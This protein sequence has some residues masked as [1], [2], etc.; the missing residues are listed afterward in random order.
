MLRREPD[1]SRF[2]NS[3]NRVTASQ[4]Y[5]R[6]PPSK[7]VSRS[8]HGAGSRQ[9]TP[10][11]SFR[12]YNRRVSRR[13][14]RRKGVED[15]VAAERLCLVSTYPPQRCGI[16][17]YTASLARALAGTGVAP[18]VI[19]ELGAH[20]GEDGGVLSVPTF[21]RNADYVAAVEASIVETG[22]TVVHVQHA[23]DIFGTDGRMPRL[24]ARLRRRGIA[25]A[26][27][28]HTVHT[29]W[30]GLLERRFGVAQFHRRLAE[31]A[32]AIVV[33][34]ARQMADE[35]ARQG[36]DTSKLSV[37]PHG[38]P[39]TPVVDR[40]L[41]RERL[42]LP[43]E[44]PMVLCFGFIHPQKNLHTVLLAT[45]EFSRRIPNCRLYLAGSLQ[46]ASWP[47]RLY[48]RLLRAIVRW[49]GLSDRVVLREEFVAED[50]MALLYAAADLVLLPYAQ[51]YG[52][53]SGVAHGAVGAAR[54]PV[55]SASPKFAEVG[56]AI[57]HGLI[58][59]T[60]SPRAWANTIA[61]LLTDEARRAALV[62][63]V[64]TFAKD[65]SWAAVAA[66]HRALYRR[67]AEA[68]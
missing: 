48:L 30:S 68:R 36:V 2:D 65:T 46:N 61:T 67:L 33:H 40:A 11:P 50:Q 34:G 12:R 64:K 57:D 60:H 16:G 13:G 43:P 15:V 26:V 37:I 52:S 32:D 63:R 14:E 18:S 20:S 56:A 54:L 35:L 44:G 58:V 31:N 47:N 21:L 10:D 4:Q 22:A 1:G 28:L 19:S 7:H 45:A 27:T 49:A 51:G 9:N 66:R 29:T 8:G 53:A 59:P 42:G 62:D 38:T 6:A 39:T 25:T 5:R 3:S 55:C 17:R 24:L 41:A 23:P